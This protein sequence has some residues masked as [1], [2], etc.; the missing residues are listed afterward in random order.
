M[1]NIYAIVIEMIKALEYSNFYIWLMWLQPL[2]S[3]CS[4]RSLLY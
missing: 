1:G 4:W 2:W 3:L